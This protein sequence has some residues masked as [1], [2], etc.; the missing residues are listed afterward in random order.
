MP[1]LEIVSIS[2]LDTKDQKTVKWSDD[3]AEARAYIEEQYKAQPLRYF[4]IFMH[5]S[6]FCRLLSW[7]TL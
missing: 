2:R 1:K 3:M 5:L 6:S 4:C 7:H